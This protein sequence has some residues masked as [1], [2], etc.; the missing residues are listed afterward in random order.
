MKKFF[1]WTI[2]IAAGLLV[3]LFLLFLGL[4]MYVNSNKK[5]LIAQATETIHTKLSGNVTIEDLN[6][7]LFR[8][9]P[10]LS[11]RLINVSVTDS[12]Y[13]K[14]QHKLLSAENLFVR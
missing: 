13:P 1:S 3:L 4:T 10:S 14:H 7:S 9:F 6:V 5:E 12:L 2:K 8:H 11:I